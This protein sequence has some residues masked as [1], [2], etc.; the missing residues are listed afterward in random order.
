MRDATAATPPEKGDITFAVFSGVNAAAIHLLEIIHQTS[1]PPTLVEGK[2][3]HVYQLSIPS[4]SNDSSLDCFKWHVGAGTLPVLIEKKLSG[5]DPDIVLNTNPDI[6]LCPPGTSPSARK[7]REALLDLHATIRFHPQTAA[8]ILKARRSSK[9]IVY[10]NGNVDG[11]DLILSRERGMN[12]CVLWQQ[13]NYL[14]IG[15]YRFVLEWIINDEDRDDF[16]RRLDK[17]IRHQYL[18]YRPSDLFDFIPR[19]DPRTIK[20]IWL[21]KQIPGYS[22]K[23][24]VDIWTGQPT[25]VQILTDKYEERQSTISQHPI[26]RQQGALGA[27]EVWVDQ[28]SVIRYSMPLPEYNFRT[29]PWKGVEANSR[30]TYLH[31]TLLGLAELHQT[32]R[33][34]RRILPESL[35]ILTN[36]ESQLLLVDDNPPPKTAVLSLSS[37]SERY[38]ES[39]CVA[40]EIW[41]NP[42]ELDRTKADIWALAASWLYAFATPPDRIKITKGTY[43]TLCITLD[44]QNKN[45]SINDPLVALFRRMLAWEPKDR[46]SAREAL[47][48]EVW[49]P[50]LEQERAIK[51]NK[52]R[53]RMELKRPQVDSRNNKRVRVLSPATDDEE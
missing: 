27:I 53:N 10:V 31:Q 21:H 6:L 24:G 7:A 29:M 48:S 32:D 36:E 40:P 49:E 47:A 18:N 1:S 11:S 8:L 35:L 42:K 45:G 13:K 20:D 28:C 19:K 41:D 44:A 25:A 51:D 5:T 16:K 14:Q 37:W 2:T 30:K 34:H 22:I 9:G 3:S 38:K 12:Q 46:P 23:T 43:H 52:K 4:S 26:M 15:E 39:L 33:T 17:K 50:V